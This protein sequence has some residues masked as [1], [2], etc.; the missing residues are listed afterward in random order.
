M[1]HSL[2][3]LNIYRKQKS[4]KMYKESRF[5]TILKVYKMTVLLSKLSFFSHSYI[6]VIKIFDPLRVRTDLLITDQIKV[7]L[8]R[9]I[10]EI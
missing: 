7:C 10:L 2:S 4:H 9:F 5:G 1:T 3:C 6:I 8:R